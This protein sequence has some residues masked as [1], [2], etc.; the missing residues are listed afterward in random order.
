M[1]YRHTVW[2]HFRWKYSERMVNHLDFSAC[3]LF[4]PAWESSYFKLFKKRDS[5]RWPRKAWAKGQWQVAGNDY[6]FEIQ[7]AGRQGIRSSAATSA[8]HLITNGSDQR[9]TQC[10][11]PG[12]VTKQELQ[13]KSHCLTHKAKKERSPKNAAY[14][15]WW[16][17][18]W[19]K[20]SISKTP[21]REGK[22]MKMAAKK[23]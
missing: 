9:R 6:L 21:R 19:G 22:E 11:E 13:S 1:W 14:R 3:V 23:I 20:Q 15:N 2:Y 16:W 7:A 12:E 18:R 17:Q 10:E 8:K 5:K 4:A